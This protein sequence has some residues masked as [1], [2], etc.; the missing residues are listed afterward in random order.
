MGPGQNNG[1][2]NTKLY[3]RIIERLD[4]AIAICDSS[5]AVHDGFPYFAFTY[6]V[7]PH[8]TVLLLPSSVMEDLKK[9]VLRSVATTA[10]TVGLAKAV[11]NSLIE[12]DYAEI[13]GL[14]ANSERSVHSQIIKMADSLRTNHRVCILSN[15]SRMLQSIQ[16]LRV[17]HRKQ[18]K[19]VSCIRL[20][21]TSNEPMIARWY[22]PATYATSYVG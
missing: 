13:N 12:N 16:Q 22:D 8:N 17:D 7:R 20:S 21:N 4:N 6:F 3:K 2:K 9:L 11:C 10:E 5:F 14:F 15:S 18:A 19:G 1:R